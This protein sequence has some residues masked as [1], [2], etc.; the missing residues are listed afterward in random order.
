MALNID[1]HPK[2]KAGESYEAYKIR[3]S[4]ENL[5]IKHYLRGKLVFCPNVPVN[6]PI[7]NKDGEW[8]VDEKGDKVTKKMLSPPFYLTSVFGPLSAL[9]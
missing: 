3:R 4:I 8:K 1:I 5:M 6:V 7:L 2:R 9:E